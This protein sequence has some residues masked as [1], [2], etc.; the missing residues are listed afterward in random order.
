VTYYKIMQYLIRNGLDSGKADYVRG[1]IRTL[2]TEKGGE[3]KPRKSNCM[4]G[5]RNCTGG[6]YEY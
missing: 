6:C 1:M 3:A 5:H 2:V 4:C